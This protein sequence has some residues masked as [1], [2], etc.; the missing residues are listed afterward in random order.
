MLS[1]QF[2]P[3]RGERMLTPILPSLI[4]SIGQRDFDASLVHCMNRICG[5]EHAA[6]YALTPDDLTGIST[7]SMDG[8]DEN[9]QKLARYIGGGLWRR[10]PTFAQ[11][12]ALLRDADRVTVRTDIAGLRDETLRELV[13]GQ[14]GIKDRVM[15]CARTQNLLIGLVMSSSEVGFSAGDNIAAVEDSAELLFS[16][17]SKH[18]SLVHSET[19]VSFALTSLDEIEACISSQMRSMPRR[20][21]EVCSRTIYGVSSLG[22]S[23]DLGI[24]VETVMTYRKRAYSRLGIA[25][26]RELFLW[27]LEAWSRWPRRTIRPVGCNLG[28]IGSSCAVN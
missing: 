20:E 6:V 25:T 26:Q 5:A 21:A 23:L 16:I 19:D 9:Y 18:I 2:S 27:Y 17:I 24:S 22:I 13:Y 14:R 28:P 15:I 3:L 4:E 1:T 8:S 12:K 11:A 7:A 10:D